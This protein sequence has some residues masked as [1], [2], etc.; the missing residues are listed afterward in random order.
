MAFS[1]RRCLSLFGRVWALS[2]IRFFVMKT[3]SEDDIYRSVKFSVWS[4]GEQAN[5]RL[6]GV[7]KDK[8]G[9]S[10]GPKSKDGG[11]SQPSW[12]RPRNVHPV[13]MAALSNTYFLCMI[14]STFV[15]S[16]YMHH[17]ICNTSKYEGVIVCV[18]VVHH[19]KWRMELICVGV[20]KR[21]DIIAA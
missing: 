19:T 18:D 13:I 3:F 10:R 5:K 4:G 9:S 11:A 20:R 14:P 17:V 21:L 6:D 1:H 16:N 2:S 7:M 8:D 15:C 12:L